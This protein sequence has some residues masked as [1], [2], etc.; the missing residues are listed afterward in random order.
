MRVRGVL[1]AYLIRITFL[2]I[3]YNQYLM[4]VYLSVINRLIRRRRRTYQ[5]DITP[6]KS[7]EQ[8]Q[9]PNSPCQLQPGWRPITDYWLTSSPKD[10]INVPLWSNT[11]TRLL[12]VSVT[13]IC[14]KLLVVTPIGKCILL[15]HLNSRLAFI[16][17]IYTISDT[18]T[19]VLKKDR[20]F[21]QL[22][23]IG[24]QC[25]LRTCNRFYRRERRDT[26]TSW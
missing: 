10:L 22:L 26:Y 20:H 4:T 11:I 5:E 9:T 18:G 7:N 19:Q 16:P 21:L 24:K 17:E 3:H 2:R 15:E 6:S 14:C 25:S 13:I 12:P 23:V 8:D 1:R